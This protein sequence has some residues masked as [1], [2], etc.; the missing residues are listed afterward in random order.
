MASTIGSLEQNIFTGSN[1]MNKLIASI[2]LFAALSSSFVAL[3]APK[4]PIN[5]SIE[6][7]VRSYHLQPGYQ[8]QMHV[9]RVLVAGPYA[10]ASWTEGDGG[11]Q[12]VLKKIGNGWKVLT[13]G[14][15]HIDAAVMIQYG[16]PKQY[17]NALDASNK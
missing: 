4:V 15:G 7:A 10:L 5:S 11:G 9:R 17:A 1:N 12:A 2:A 16:V 13:L 8:S 14:G 6:K 3:A